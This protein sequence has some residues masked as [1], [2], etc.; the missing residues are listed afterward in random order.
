VSVIEE[1][2]WRD[3]NLS[4][5]QLS[6]SRESA[7]SSSGG[8]SLSLRVHWLCDDLSCCLSICL[9]FAIVFN[10][11]LS[12]QR[13]LLLSLTHPPTTGT[14]TQLHTIPLHFISWHV[15]CSGS[16]KG[17]RPPPREEIPREHRVLQQSYRL[18]SY[19]CTE[20]LQQR[21]LSRCS[22]SPRGGHREL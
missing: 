12:L 21:D 7:S 6:G 8:R 13:V 4:L 17:Q 22:W 14:S 18:G 16:E 20:S 19:E 9:L 11:I 3:S 10:I 2:I 1:S 5:P 15:R